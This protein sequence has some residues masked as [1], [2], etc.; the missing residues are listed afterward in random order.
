MSSPDR[1]HTLLFLPYLGHYP[2]PEAVNMINSEARKNPGNELGGKRRVFLHRE[3][4]TADRSDYPPQARA[5]PL[6][7]NRSVSV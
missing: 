4:P 6:F 5:C 1:S 2:E 3:L 7:R